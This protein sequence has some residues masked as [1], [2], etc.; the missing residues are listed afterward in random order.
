MKNEHIEFVKKW[1]DDTNSVSQEARGAAITATAATAAHAA[2]A[3]AD[4][5]YWVEKYEEVTKSEEPYATSKNC[6]LEAAAIAL[7]LS[8]DSEYMFKQHLTVQRLWGM[9]ER[10]HLANK[11]EE[12]GQ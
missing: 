9:G 8:M 10:L 12:Q 3:A 1:L 11:L 6:E 2:R 5:A 4:T 7:H